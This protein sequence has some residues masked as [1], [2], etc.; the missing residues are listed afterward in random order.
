[1]LFHYSQ[2]VLHVTGEHDGRPE[3]PHIYPT[4]P[5]G[6]NESSVVLSDD[7][8]RV[9]VDGRAEMRCIV[10]GEYSLQTDGSR[11]NLTDGF[12]SPGFRFYDR[13]MKLSSKTLGGGG[14]KAF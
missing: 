11:S 9:P 7:E 14:N 2:S 8:F 12:P 5:P 4:Y 6:R 10:K 1:M 13:H 3:P